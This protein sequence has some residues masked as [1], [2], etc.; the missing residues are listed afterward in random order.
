MSRSA[1]LKSWS[2]VV[3][4]ALLAGCGSSETDASGAGAAGGRPGS[5]GGNSTVSATGNGGNLGGGF[6]GSAA[7]GA[8]TGTAGSG[9]GVPGGGGTTSG[10][11]GTAGG[12]AAGALAA[13]G[14]S[15]DADAAPPGKT[16]MLAG[17]NVHGYPKPTAYGFTAADGKDRM[18]DALVALGSPVVRG[19]TIGDTAFLARLASFGVKEVALLLSA[20]AEGKPFDPAAL[21]PLLKKSVDAAKA[22][23]ITVQVEG[24]NEWDLFN[25]RTYNAGVLPSGMTASQFVLY[26]QKAL[27]EAAHPL[28]ITVLGPSVG[29][30]GDAPNLAFFPDVSA[31]VDVVNMHS[32]FTSNPEGLPMAK[33]VADHEHF[34][35]KGKPLWVTETGI[36]AYGSVSLDAQADVVRRGLAVYAA[37]KL[38]ARSY[39]YELLDTQL[40]GI[41]GGTNTP[42]SGEYHFGLFTFEGTAKP[43]ATSF[44]NFV[45]AP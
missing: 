38:I 36:S 41:S 43:V 5:S 39:I 25:G 35:G 40:P 22:L 10:G 26:T 19:G 13:G 31:Y 3:S 9:G 11:A 33:R 20:S 28:G 21:G 34:Q 7:G 32:Y 16:G 12:G 44:Q 18:G 42:D 27:Y 17:V 2:L 29:H 1:S 14:S 8:G 45:G 6:G 24:L 30:P 4:Y 15:N 37:T 23:G